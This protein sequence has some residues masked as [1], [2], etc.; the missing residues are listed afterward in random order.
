MYICIYVYMYT[1]IYVLYVYMYICIIHMYICMYVYMYI[2][3]YVCMEKCKN[4]NMHICIYVYMYI[5]IYVYM[6]VC[7]YVCIYICVYIYM[8]FVYICIYIYIPTYTCC[9]TFPW[10]FQGC[11]YAVGVYK[12]AGITSVAPRLDERCAFSQRP[13][14]QRRK[15]KFQRFTRHGSSKLGMAYRF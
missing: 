10:I 8:V 2:C 5:C 1:C 4:V 3:I 7:M 11:R 9:S 15:Q 14:L 13:S 6:Y 12:R